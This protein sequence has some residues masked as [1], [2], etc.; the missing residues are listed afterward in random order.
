MT[1]N[2]ETST[3]SEAAHGEEPAPPKVRRRDASRNRDL[4]IEAAREAMASGEVVPLDRIA[5]AAGVGIATLYRHFPH[6]EELDRAV[7]QAVFAAEIEP[8]IELIHPEDPRGSFLVVAERLVHVVTRYRPR[9][10]ASVDLAQVASVLLEVGEP[11]A[12]LLEEGKANGKLRPDLE[13]VDALWMLHMLV[14]GF[15][16]AET[17]AQVRARSF[18]L[19]W[20]AISGTAREPLPPL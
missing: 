16:S 13:P 7:Y 17:T 19:M 14:A 10:G 8:I 15:A 6:R 1:A 11:F 2:D 12:A 20:D 9:D 4:I 3:T 18:A 5:A